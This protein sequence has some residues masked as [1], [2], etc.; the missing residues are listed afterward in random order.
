[1][2]KY[3]NYAGQYRVTDN[4]TYNAENDDAIGS[5]MKELGYGVSD[6]FPEIWFASDHGKFEGE[7]FKYNYG[8]HLEQEIVHVPIICSSRVHNQSVVDNVFSM[9]EVRRLLTRNN[10]IGIP[11]QKLD[12]IYICRNSISW[13][14]THWSEKRQ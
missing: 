10:K 11:G 9:K 2:S 8:Y 4:C 3:I 12:E 6:D 5:L 7:A 13:S 14:N 1:M